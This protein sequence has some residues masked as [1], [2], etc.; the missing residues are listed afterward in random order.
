[1]VS[2][3]VAKR[4]LT[5]MLLL[6]LASNIRSAASFDSPVEASFLNDAKTFLVEEGGVYIYE[7]RNSESF[8]LW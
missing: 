1:M 6:G 7:C 2:E 8:I 4:K 3:G 5:S